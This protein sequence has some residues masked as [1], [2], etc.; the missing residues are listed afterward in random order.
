MA[1]LKKIIKN[2]FREVIVKWTGSGS[3]TLTLASLIAASQTI[4]G[5]PTVNILAVAASISGVGECT[6]T[7]NSQVALH[8][9][10][11]FEFQTDGIISAVLDENNS[12]DIVV[13]LTTIGTLI[14]R[15]KKIQGYT[16]PIL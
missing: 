13:N 8:M 7:R 12:F 6:I 9:H 1:L 2:D 4:S 11:N 10:D 3:D 15:V 14:V 16:A 5:T